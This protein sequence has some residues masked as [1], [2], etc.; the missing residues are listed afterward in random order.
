MAEMAVSANGG[1]EFD[2][3]IVKIWLMKKGRLGLELYD[4]GFVLLVG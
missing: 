4:E 3:K 2:E 1:L